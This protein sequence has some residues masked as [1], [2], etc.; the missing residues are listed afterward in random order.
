MLNHNEA[1]AHVAE[2][3][4]GQHAMSLEQQTAKLLACVQAARR[5]APHL[6]S[7][8]ALTTYAETIGKLKTQHAELAAAMAGLNAKMEEAAQLLSEA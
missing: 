1:A 8:R 3:N 2:F 6:I 7:A 4:R 5:G